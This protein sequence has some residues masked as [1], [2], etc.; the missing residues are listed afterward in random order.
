MKN[1]ML[2]PAA[3]CA[4][5]LLSGAPSVVAQGQQALVIQ[6]G[7]L[8]DGNGGAPLANAVIVV[9]GNRI[10]QVGRAGQV[11][12]PAGAQVVDARGKWVIPGLIDAKAN[13]NWQYGEGFLVWGVT[14]AVASGGTIGD[15][16]I[17]MRD[18]INHGVFA[19]P[20]LFQPQFQ[21]GGP[22]PKLDKGKDRE[23]GDGEITPFSPQEAQTLARNAIEAGADF[24]SISNGDGAPEIY[25]AAVAEA[26]RQ[27]KGVAFRAMGPQTRAREVA[28]M[29]GRIVCIHTC[30]VGSQIAKD[31]S[32]WATYVGLPPDQYADMDDAKA[33]AMIKTLV[34]ADIYLEPDI[35]AT[36]R[37][38][39]KNW[40]R[41]QDET[42]SFFTDPNLLAYYPLRSIEDVKENVK[43]P[44]TFLTPEKRAIR[45]AGFKNHMAFLKRF[46]D[47]GGKIVA[48]SDISQSVPGLGLHQEMA[49]FQ[50]DIGLTPRQA[51]LAGTSWVADGFG[52]AD[53]GRIQ[54]GKL[55]DIVIVDADPQ[56]D[57]LNMR[58]VSNVIKDGKLVD[59]TYHRDYKGA[60]F[61]NDTEYDF[62]TAPIDNAAWVDAL[63]RT[64]WRPNVGATRGEPGIPG[65]VPDFNNSP[66]PGIEEI[67]L[68]T[69]LR[70][71]PAQTVTIKGFNYTTRSQLTVDD[72]PVPTQVVSRTELRAT[73]DPSLFAQAGKI[74]LNVK[75]PKPLLTPEW[76]DTSNP[77]YILVPFEFTTAYSHNK[78]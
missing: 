16:G 67:S 39:P 51:L 23:F 5:L 28:A 56:A 46:V 1:R 60:M 36:G 53:V 21:I 49:V 34:A 73:L 37:G 75:H 17:A 45:E 2:R 35:I 47:A 27:G 57:I 59:R 44:E 78:F 25:A 26:T 7:T 8:I 18:A 58:K 54:A 40:K 20:R 68:H 14:S 63:K 33:A 71:S 13:Y 24:I 10:A 48:A 72:K 12:V 41:H 76:G 65:R 43:G 70:G 22:G 74:R 3:M 19:A 55:A 32:K 50:E 38:F 11:R 9:Q 31:E 4:A 52:L 69:V 42:N 6:G 30:N 77:A 29:R 64:T 62:A 15:T 66:T 61:N